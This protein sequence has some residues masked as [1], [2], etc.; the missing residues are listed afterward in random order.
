MASVEQTAKYDPKK[1]ENHLKLK[2]MLELSTLLLR[3]EFHKAFSN[4]PSTLFNQLK[5]KKGHLSELRRQKK[6]NTLQWKLLYPSNHLVDSSKFDVSLL[7][8]LLKKFCLGTEIPVNGW[9]GSPDDGDNSRAA[10]ILRIYHA[11]NNVQHLNLE[12]SD[13]DFEQHWVMFER[14]AISL[15]GDVNLM[16]D[17]KNTPVLPKSVRGKKWEVFDPVTTFFGRDKELQDLHVILMEESNLGA[18]VCAFAG[19]GKTELCKAYCQE[20]S[21]NYDGNLLWLNAESRNTIEESFRDIAQYLKQKLTDEEGQQLSMKVL[22]KR[23]FQYF[24]NQKALFIFDNVRHFTDIKVFLPDD[25]LEFPPKILIT[26]QNKDWAGR[27]AKFELDIFSEEEA[28]TFLT[29]NLEDTKFDDT[30]SKKGLAETL[31]FHPLALQITASF[32]KRRNIS[33]QKFLEI[34][35]ENARKILERSDTANTGYAKTVL[36]AFN[37]SLLTVSTHNE[38]AMSMLLLNAMSRIDGKRLEEDILV[39]LCE[40]A[41]FDMFDVID[42]LEDNSFVQMKATKDGKVFY[43]MH[44]LIQLVVQLSEEIALTDCTNGEKFLFFAEE[45]LVG[46]SNVVNISLKEDQNCFY[47]KKLLNTIL[48]LY[49]QGNSHDSIQRQLFG[50]TLIHTDGDWLHHILYLIKGN[51]QSEKVMIELER[52][53]SSV[54]HVLVNRG[55]YSTLMDILKEYFTHEKKF[56][57]KTELINTKR[58]IAKC[59]RLQG[60]YEKALGLLDEISAEE[61]ELSTKPENSQTKHLIAMCVL[62]QGRYAIALSKFEENCKFDE[63]KYGKNDLRTLRSKYMTAMCLRNQGHYLKSLEL[64]QDIHRVEKIILPEKDTNPLLT[65]HMIGVCSQDLGHYLKAHD[66]FTE[67]CELQTSILGR[68]HPSTL[69]SKHMVAICLLRKG[70]GWD[71]FEIFKENYE[72]QKEIHGAHNPATIR[73][74]HNMARCVNAEGKYEDALAILTEN[75]EIQKALITDDHPKTLRTKH[76]MAMCLQFQ[77]R[78]ANAY[79]QFYNLYLQKVKVYTEKNPS[80]LITLFRVCWCLLEQGLYERALTMFREVRKKEI[81]LIKDSP[82]TLATS[83]MIAWCLLFCGKY[84]E[85]SQLFQDNYAMEKEKLGEL[86]PRSIRSRNMVALCMKL[87]GK[88]SEE[89]EDCNRNKDEELLE[90]N[91][92]DEYLCRHTI[93]LFLICREEYSRALSVF[94]QNLDVQQGFQKTNPI[95]LRTKYLIGFCHLQLNEISEAL[96][97]LQANMEDVSD[98]YELVRLRHLIAVCYWRKGSTTQALKLFE[99]NLETITSSFKNNHRMLLTTQHVLAVCRDELGDHKKSRQL[100]EDVYERK[101][102]MLGEASPSTVRTSRVIE[103]LFRHHLHLHTNLTSGMRE[104]KEDYSD[105]CLIFDEYF[106]KP[107]EL[108]GEMN[109]IYAQYMSNV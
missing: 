55:T 37:T 88:R 7:F 21:A 60:K 64:F 34:F 16:E 40:N 79:E 24:A 5:K 65:N 100:L 9:V 63:R 107:Q 22:V 72:I 61:K 108:I 75:Y 80:T 78:F 41:G 42:V 30:F 32:M 28:V 12:V 85:A 97:I 86:S 68:S 92:L 8:I 6:I 69:L 33:C 14:A 45:L 13:P 44:S 59:F 19:V 76:V 3:N 81:Q 17:I 36:A 47:V 26:S 51:T 1:T 50:D 109:T 67:N 91:G 66:I 38:A 82:N 46:G 15:G 62:D 27:I 73:S 106:L 31:E 71:A 53:K 10:N 74:R 98:S 102:A 18:A 29:E 4:S 35:K 101:K 90:K 95:I 2:R 52:F 84:M 96:E 25:S 105:E 48:S 49:G 39:K 94:L 43:T 57:N 56:N 104:H 54:F 93:G 89:L 70:R 11:R 58:Y 103:F 77:G 23:I 83:G 20:Q 99:E 87:Q